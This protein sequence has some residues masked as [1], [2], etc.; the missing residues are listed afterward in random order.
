M[1]RYHRY[2][3]NGDSSASIKLF[4]FATRHQTL[5]QREFEC[6]IAGTHQFPLLIVKDSIKYLLGPSV[7]TPTLLKQPE[8]ILKKFTL[9][10]TLNSPQTNQP[11]LR[12]SI[13]QSEFKITSHC[14]QRSSLHSWN[15]DYQE[16]ISRSALMWNTLYWEFNCEDSSSVV[17][18]M[19]WV[20]V[21]QD[22]SAI[23]CYWKVQN[24]AKDN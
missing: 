7:Y 22:M 16:K 9:Y 21:V 14:I 17:Y 4:R 24:S 3:L 13:A 1:P 20:E 2:C 8:G 19:F 15:T 18:W 23:V 5:S 6:P 10:S 12:N 11:T